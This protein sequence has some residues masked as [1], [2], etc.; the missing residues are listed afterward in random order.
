MLD[1]RELGR[2]PGSQRE[3]SRTVP[4]PADL[5]IEVLQVPEGSPVEMDLRLEAVME[6]VLVT[7]TAHADYIYNRV[8]LNAITSGNFDANLDGTISPE[9]MRPDLAGRV[10]FIGVNYYFRAVVTGIGAAITPHIPLFDFIPTTSYRTV[11]NPSAPPCPS[12]CSDFGWEIYPAGLREML[13]IVGALGVPVYITENGIADA[14]DTLRGQYIYDHLATLQQAIADD[15]ADVRGYFHW[16]LTDNFE[17]ASGYYPKF[18]L[19][20]FDPTTARK[21][22]TPSVL[23]P[24][25]QKQMALARAQVNCIDGELAVALHF[26]LE[27]FAL[28]VA[29]DINLH[30]THG[31]IRNHLRPRPHLIAH[32]GERTSEDH[33]S[34]GKLERH[35][36]LLDQP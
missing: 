15:V 33:P 24:N 3:M 35:V 8:F 30:R 25:G 4:A 31:G 32:R 18:G 26:Q 34:L 11:H 9:E 29:G 17:W 14:G 13:T 36:Q 1:T 23:V 27:V 22:N 21:W 28:T 7:G 12:V 10:D 5:G 19:A 16:S 2:R 20:S 6:G